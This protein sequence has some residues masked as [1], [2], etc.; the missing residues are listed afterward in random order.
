MS[1]DSIIIRPMGNDD[2][3]PVALILTRLYQEFGIQPPVESHSL[4]DRLKDFGTGSVPSF[5]AFIAFY[6]ARACGILIYSKTFDPVFSHIG[7]YVSTLYV[8]ESAR[9]QKIGSS[10]VAK[11][12]QTALRSRWSHIEWSTKLAQKNAAPFLEKYFQRYHKTNSHIIF[13]EDLTTWA[14]QTYIQQ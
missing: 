12:A 14:K 6:K 7:C 5:Q 9:G 11:L 8:V 4:A 1:S 3:E 2:V 13:G 10:L